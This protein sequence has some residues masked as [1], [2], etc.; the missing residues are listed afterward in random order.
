M[1]LYFIDLR[2]FLA[3]CAKPLSLQNTQQIVRQIVEGVDFLHSN[4]RPELDAI[5]DVECGFSTFSKIVKS[6]TAEKL[7]TSEGFDGLDCVLVPS[8]GGNGVRVFL[9]S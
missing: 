6:L 2:K 4:G 5:K 8:G 3:R 7:V 9:W 1:C